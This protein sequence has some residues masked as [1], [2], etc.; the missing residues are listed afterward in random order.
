M[1][2]PAQGQCLVGELRALLKCLSASSDTFPSIGPSELF[3]CR[4]KWSALIAAA[5]L[6]LNAIDLQL[7]NAALDRHRLLNDGGR[8][9]LLD[10]SALDH[11]RWFFGTISSAANI[12]GSSRSL[13]LLCRGSV[14]TP[15]SS[16]SV[17]GECWQDSSCFLGEDLLRICTSSIQSGLVTNVKESAQP[18]LGEYSSGPFARGQF[19]TALI[20]PILCHGERLGVVVLLDKAGQ[21]P[22]SP[23]D[24][25]VCVVTGS[26]IGD[27]CGRDKIL[28]TVLEAHAG[29]YLSH[30]Q[31]EYIETLS[32]G[33]SRTNNP[34]Y[35]T[36][37]SLRIHSQ[38]TTRPQWDR[39]MKPLTRYPTNLSALVSDVQLKLEILEAAQEDSKAKLNE[40]LERF[41]ELQ[42]RYNSLRTSMDVAAKDASLLRL[43]NHRLMSRSFMEV[44]RTDSQPDATVENNAYAPQSPRWNGQARYTRR[45]L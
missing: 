36:W 20:V 32:L 9:T 15:I 44:T 31:K 38:P 14:L 25:C 33:V 5:Q 24:E 37:F 41:G 7:T 23:K 18:S 43:A 22:Y 2:A 8:G 12:T 27:Y 26:L 17:S 11:F 1:D 39:G 6:K 10:P 13:L 45:R 28:N 34:V 3:A 19:S 30:F 29:E 4:K 21:L 42:T 16:Y 35:P 40:T